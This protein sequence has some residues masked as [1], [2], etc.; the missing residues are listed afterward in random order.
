MEWSKYNHFWKNDKGQTM[1]YNSLECRLAIMEEEPRCDLSRVSEDLDAY[2]K[3]GFVYAGDETIKAKYIYERSKYNGGYLEF[4]VYVTN[5]CDFQCGYC[6]ERSTAQFNKSDDS[7]SNDTVMATVK[8]ILSKTAILNYSSVKITYMGGEPTLNITA[9]KLLSNELLKDENI[10]F[11][12]CIVTNGYNLN[13]EYISILRECRVLEYQITLDGP[14]RVHDTRRCL[15]SGEGTYDVILDNIHLLLKMHD[16]VQIN[17]RMNCD[18]ENIEHIKLLIKLLHM[19]GLNGKVAINIGEIVACG[20]ISNS[21]LRDKILQATAYAKKLGFQIILSRL[22]KCWKSSERWF[23]IATDGNVYKC[24]MDVDSESNKVANVIED[25]T[26]NEYY[27]LINSE[28]DTSCLNCELFG[29][30][31]GGCNNEK[32]KDDITDKKHCN[33]AYLKKIIELEYS[34]YFKEMG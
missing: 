15:K 29:L 33:K 26:F 30:C 7:M 23:L 6:F 19:Q 3:N 17:I 18:E 13:K 14:Q 2:Y 10:N 4:W 20:N 8:W 34:N 1:I 28:I 32:M 31:A 16:K 11:K 12:F 21:N 5:K 25:I 9:I 22:N 24:P 27:E